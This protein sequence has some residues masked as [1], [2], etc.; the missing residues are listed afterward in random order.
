MVKENPTYVPLGIISGPG[1][2]TAVLP[3]TPHNFG[4]SAQVASA[5]G[6]LGFNLG[7]EHYPVTEDGVKTLGLA[8]VQILR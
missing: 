3:T 1:I 4:D 7:L 2:C 5:R 6:Y 8:V